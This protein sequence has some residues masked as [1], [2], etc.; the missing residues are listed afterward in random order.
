MDLPNHGDWAEANATA[1]TEPKVGNELIESYFKRDLIE[2]Y[3]GYHDISEDFPG[4]AAV[5]MIQADSYAKRLHIYCT[6]NGII[7]YDSRLHEIATTGR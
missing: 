1:P 4:E 3:I 7:G 5:A 2:A 6:W